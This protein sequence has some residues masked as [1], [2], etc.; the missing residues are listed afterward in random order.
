MSKR[1][2]EPQNAPWR[3]ARDSPGEAVVRGAEQLQE[4]EDLM[5]GK[6]VE[7]SEKI[8]ETMS[9]R[10]SSEDYVWHTRTECDLR[11]RCGGSSRCSSRRMRRRYEV[12]A[13]WKLI[14]EVAK[15]FLHHGG[16]DGK[17]RWHAWR[18]G[19]EAERGRNAE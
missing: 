4:E 11:S 10:T 2:E 15:D 8:K 1:G 19:I 14:D 9:S 7:L 3:R 18:A 17:I 5:Q 16:V 13:R 6:G 12:G